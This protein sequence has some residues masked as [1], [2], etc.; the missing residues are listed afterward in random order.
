MQID[1][2]RNVVS[3]IVPIITGS[4]TVLNFIKNRKNKRIP[5]YT[6]MTKSFIPSEC[7]NLNDLKISY[8][9]IDIESFSVTTFAFWNNGKTELSFKDYGKTPPYLSSDKFK[10]LDYSILD[11]YDNSFINLKEEFC[12]NKLSFNY[13][14]ISQNQGFVVKVLHT[15]NTNN[16]IT[17]NFNFNNI[18]CKRIMLFNRKRTDIFSKLAFTTLWFLLLLLTALF[19]FSGILSHAEPKTMLILVFSFFL[20]ILVLVSNIR[21]SYIPYFGIPK[22]FQKYFDEIDY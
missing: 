5:S 12:D 14:T 13:N 3:I 18:K 19:I 20:L 22:R 6:L 2:I 21:E 7:G 4:I 15:G 8:K 17:F 10:I 9:N 16:D 1:D 11:I